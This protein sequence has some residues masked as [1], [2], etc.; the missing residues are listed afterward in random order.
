MSTICVRCHRRRFATFIPRTSPRCPSPF[1]TVERAR[2]S[3][4]LL[5]LVWLSGTAVLGYRLANGSR[6]VRRLR[7][8]AREIEH[9]KLTA[10]MVELRRCENLPNAPIRFS[11][12]LHSPV[13]VGPRRTTVILPEKLLD[14]LDEQQ[15]RCVLAHELTHVR[16]RDPLVGLIQRIVEASYWPHPLV[17]LLNRD[18][19]RAREE[20]CDNAAL[21]GTTAPQYANTL[22]TVALGTPNHRATPGTVGLMTPRWRLEERVKGLLD[23]HRRLNTTM[24]LRHLAIMATLLVGGTTH[25]RRR[26]HCGRAKP[27]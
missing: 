25:H 12:K 16:Q 14:Q 26:A 13:V 4:S 19:I 11:R 15:L 23:P 20:V 3:A 9:P 27:P 17:H 2:S 10:A 6:K 5:L 1:W 21:H 24:N 8:S 18:L 22:L 7:S